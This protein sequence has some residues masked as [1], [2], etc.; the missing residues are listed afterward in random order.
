MAGR[1]PPGLPGETAS[2]LKFRAAPERI[3]LT[4]T[5]RHQGAA[6]AVAVAGVPERGEHKFV[7]AKAASARRPTAYMEVQEVQEAPG[8]SGSP[9]QPVVVAGIRVATLVQ[10]LSEPGQAVPEGLPVRP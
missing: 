5:G 3:L 2:F 4:T 1:I 8:V 6:A 10:F 7:A 9:V